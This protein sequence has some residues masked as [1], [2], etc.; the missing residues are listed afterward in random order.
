M[1]RRAALLAVLTLA[2]CEELSS[3]TGSVASSASAP[4]PVCGLTGPALGTPIDSAGGYTV[5]DTAP[6]S[7]APRVHNVTG[8]SDG[9]ARP[10]VAALALFGDPATFETTLYDGPPE[11][12]SLTA[13]AYE[14]IKSRICG[15]PRG[16][17]C[18]DGLGRLSRNTAF[19]TLYPVFGGE[20]HTDLLLHAGEVVAVD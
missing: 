20:Q 17:P 18:G 16:Q 19:L 5:H 4:A 2:A 15:V 14:E 10:V 11:A 7:T 3:P 1:L 13:R 8:F 6:G 9:C 12:P